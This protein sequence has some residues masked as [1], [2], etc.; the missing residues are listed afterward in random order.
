MTTAPEPCSYLNEERAA[1]TYR[2]YTAMTPEHLERLISRG[3]RRFNLQIFRPSCPNCSQCIGIRVPSKDFRPSRSQRRIWKQNQH[4]TWDVQPATVSEQ[5][6]ELY[7]AW[8]TERTQSR[9]WPVS[10]TNLIDYQETFLFGNFPSLHEFRY[11]DGD[12]LVGVG[13]VDVMPNSLSSAYF[14]YS[15]AWASFSPGT[16]SALVELEFARQ[17]G[18]SHVYF[19]Y[20]IEKCSSMAYK[21]RFQPCELL[22]GY[23]ADDAEPVWRRAEQGTA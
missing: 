14:Y 19:G 4:I 12:T 2:V 22:T 13:L 21:N 1:L 9:G 23:P 15:P 16:F 18:R 10:Q 8:H 7:N 5:H 17:T 11:F 3:W 20:W 6:V